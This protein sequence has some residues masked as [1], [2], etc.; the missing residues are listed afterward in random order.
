M[1]EEENF[2]AT[3]EEVNIPSMMPAGEYLSYIRAVTSLYITVATVIA[4]IQISVA[5][6]DQ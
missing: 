3:S 6:A 1:V 2:C 5:F 4:L